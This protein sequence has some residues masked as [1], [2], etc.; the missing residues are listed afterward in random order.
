ML[1]ILLCLSTLILHSLGKLCADSPNQT[2]ENSTQPFKIEKADQESPLHQI[3]ETINLAYQRQPFNRLD[4]PRITIAALEELL[5]N[6]ENVLYI[7]ISKE[8]EICGTVLL[9]GA[10][11]SLLSVHPRHQGK[12]LGLHLLHYAE[13]K[14]FETSDTVFLKVIPLFQEKLI[15]YYA[16]A[17]YKSLGEYEPLSQEKLKRI[18]EQYHSEVFALIMRKENPAKSVD[19][20]L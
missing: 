12:E 1:H 3:V 9:H 7:A 20:T 8:N 5:Q 16:S 10:E 4:Y 13:Q 15:R 11:I 18:Q 19:S 6:R 14:A 2:I 17:G